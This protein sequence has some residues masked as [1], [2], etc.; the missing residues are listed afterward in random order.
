[1]PLI[2]YRIRDVGRIKRA[3]CTCSRGLPLMELAGG[4]VTDFLVATN[5]DR[6]SGIVV[7]T[8]VITNL[9]GIRQVQFIQNEAGAVTVN[10]V[11]GP[12]WSEGTMAELAARIRRY[13][14]DDIRLQIE[15]RDQI[16]LERSGKYRF[17]ISTL[18]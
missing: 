5:G 3:H 6:V 1:M 7:S 18:A 2:R 12:G 13:L 8:Y 11:K 14:G 15:F 17:S 16:P 10:L 9:P 4:R